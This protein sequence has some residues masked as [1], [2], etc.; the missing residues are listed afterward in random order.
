MKYRTVKISGQAPVEKWAVAASKGRHYADTVCDTRVD[1][2]EQAMLMSLRWYYDQA[3]SVY[4]L[5]CKEYPSQYGDHYANYDG[6]LADF[7]D[8]LC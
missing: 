2:D 1:A 4:D 7:G 8:L 5:L 6:P 3:R